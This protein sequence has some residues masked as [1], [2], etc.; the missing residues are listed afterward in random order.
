MAIRKLLP[1]DAAAFQSIRLRGL[2]EC[3]EAFS[4]SYAEERDT[5]LQ[6]IAQRLTSKPDG[7]V[8]G[9]FLGPDLVGVIGVER[10]SR[11]K[12]SHKASIWG[13]YVAPEHRLKG[14][15]RALVDQ[16]L[17]HAAHSL[18]VQLIQLGVNTHNAAAIAL[19]ESMGFLTYGTELGFLM[20]DGVSHDQ[21]LMS[22]HV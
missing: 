10:E 12:L 16:A 3:P 2:L 18:T 20:L 14:M 21:H 5:P 6:I 22:R 13:M 15:G 4:S 1:E 11:I 9:S 19:Y 17:Q 8:F 7:A